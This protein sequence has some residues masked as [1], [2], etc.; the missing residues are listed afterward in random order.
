MFQQTTKVYATS[1]EENKRQIPVLVAMNQGWEFAHLLI[2][3]LLIRSFCSNQMS[4][5]ERFTQIAQDKWATVSELLR[6]LKTNEQPWANPSG[7]SWQMSDREQITQVLM[8]NEQMSDSL[9]KNLAKKSKIL[10]FSIIYKGFFI[11]KN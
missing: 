8:I 10:F 2:T 5:Y 3:H 7:R 1:N 11:L 6:S 4:D 9:K